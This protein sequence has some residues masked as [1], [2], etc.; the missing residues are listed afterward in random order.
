MQVAPL[1]ERDQLLD[2]GLDRLGLRLAGLDPLVL[3]QLPRQVLHQR[4]AVSRV[5]AQLVSCPLVAHGCLAPEPATRPG[6]RARGRASPRSPLR[7]SARRSSGSPSAP[8]PTSPAGRRSSA[9]RPA[10]GSCRRGRRSRAP[11]SA[12]RRRSPPAPALAGRPPAAASRWSGSAP[13]RRSASVKIARLAI[14]SSAAS[15]SAE[16]GSIEPSVSTCERELVEVRAL[17]DAGGVDAVGRAPDRRED[18]VD[19]DDADRLVLG[20]V[21]LGRRVA[22]AAADRQ[23]HLELRLLLERRDRRLGVEDLDAGRAGRCHRR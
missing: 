2:L 7:S 20:L 12:D 13:R 14:I 10:S 18:R 22:A 21:V 15:R 8:T 9:R 16:P 3:D 11:R 17:T 1:G 19:R 6:G 5:A 23:V 4:L